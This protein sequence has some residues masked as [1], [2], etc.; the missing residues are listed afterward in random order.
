MK[1][2]SISPASRSG[3]TEY[4]GV[5]GSLSLLV[6]TLGA[7]IRSGSRTVSKWPMSGVM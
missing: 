4:G 5:S 3:A 1:I 7:L 6:V 2:Q